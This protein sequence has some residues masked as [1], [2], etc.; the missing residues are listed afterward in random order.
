[1][2]KLLLYLVLL[3]L[4]MLQVRSVTA[5]QL[6][7]PPAS[8]EEL[9]AVY[10]TSIET[11][12][13]A[14]LAKLNLTDSAKSNQ[15][16]DIIIAQYRVLRER[17]EAIDAKLKG[18]GLSINYSN[19][20]PE[21]AAAS[22]PLHDKFI[23]QLNAVLTPDQVDQVKDLMTYN[24][25]TFTYDAYCNIVPNL[26]DA[27]KAKIMEFLK[28][29]RE[30]AVDGGSAPEKSSIFQKYKDQI[31]QYLDAQG[32]NVEKSMEQWSAAH[33]TASAAPAGK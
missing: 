32:H 10:T 12:T 24:K 17:D 20:A 3:S 25:V 1:M 11:R 21:L 28:Q 7:T 29:A 4:V 9:E 8:K 30:E 33:T 16:H 13:E 19:R 15:V 6:S 5:Q 22:K 26:S 14:I 31:N 2:K 27:D 18:Q 23:S